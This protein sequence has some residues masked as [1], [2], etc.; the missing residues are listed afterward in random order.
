[1]NRLRHGCAMVFGLFFFLAAAHGQFSYTDQNTVNSVSGQFV[2]SGAGSDVQVVRDPALAANTNIVYLKTA[3]LAVSAERFKISL[4]QQLGIQPNA[5]WSGKVYLQ[6]HPARTP[7]ET[8]TIMSGPFLNHWNYRV[9][10]PDML[11]KT[12][13]ARAMTGVLLLELANRTSKPG[14]HSA[15]LPPWLVDGLAQQ[16][17]ATDADKIILSATAKKGDELLV[18]QI[19]LLNRSKV[20]ER[21]FDPLAASRQILLTQPVMTFDQ[22]SWPTDAQMEGADGGAYLASA[23]LFQ[24]E[25]LKLKNG[26]EKMR[27]MLAEL[28]NYLNWQTAFFRAFGQDFQKPVD[29]EKWWALRVVNFALRAPSGP[30]WPIDVSIVRLQEAMNVTVEYRSNSNALPSYA[31]VPLQQAL[32]TLNPEQRDTVM[33]TKVRDLALL[34]LRL[35]PPFVGL[36]EGY[37]VALEGFLGELMP[38][39]QAPVSNKHGV[40][41]VRRTSMADTVK[42]LDA[43]D[44]RRSD[45]ETKSVM[46][47]PGN[48]QASTP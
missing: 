47:L 48:T 34:E 38:A 25:L 37:R 12:R 21:G 6:V 39:A 13:Y 24:S 22:L 11:W 9:G 27:T 33:R 8:V 17:L 43:L 30:H 32:K 26:K 42:Q 16:V 2:V 29:V 41:V 46:I 4:W 36:A 40:P 18:N 20:P 15:E 28:P 35:A 14:G 10:L 31:E 23:Q 3:L 19:N 45:V 1:M 44:R 5:N 7:D